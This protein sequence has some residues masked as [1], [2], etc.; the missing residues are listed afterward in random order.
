MGV[1]CDGFVDIS[2]RWFQRCGM[3][4]TPKIGGNKFRSAYFFQAAITYQP[5]VT[6]NSQEVQVEQAGTAWYRESFLMDNPEDQMPCKSNHQILFI[7]WFT[8]YKPQ[9]LIVRVYHHPKGTIFKMVATTSRAKIFVF[10]GLF[11]LRGILIS[12]LMQIKSLYKN[13]GVF[14]PLFSPNQLKGKLITAVSWPRFLERGEWV[15]RGDPRYEELC[16][17]GFF[18]KAKCKEPKNQKPPKQK[19]KQ[20][21]ELG[22]FLF[23]QSSFA[24]HGHFFRK[25]LCDIIQTTHR[26]PVGPCRSW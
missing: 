21:E 6:F 9:F 1:F 22:V 14:H 23:P 20:P 4:F 10:N 18:R 25:F 8:V 12:G 3:T 15:P 16:T 2:V 17:A 13:W 24:F 5:E 11:F 7:C 26:L 19:K